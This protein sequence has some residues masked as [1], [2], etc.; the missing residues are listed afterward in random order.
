MEFVPLQGQWDLY[1]KQQGRS[2]AQGRY[3]LAADL[4]ERY[5]PVCVIGNHVPVKLGNEL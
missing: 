2:K 4:Q 5:Y 3:D 1:K